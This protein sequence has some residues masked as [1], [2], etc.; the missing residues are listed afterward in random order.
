MR[1][2]RIKLKE[3]E[4]IKNIMHT[5]KKKKNRDIP[6]Q[7]NNLIL[8][9]IVQQ[10]KNEKKSMLLSFYV[11]IQD[12][13]DKF[14]SN[15]CN[16]TGKI[17]VCFITFRASLQVDQRLARRPERHRRIQTHSTEPGTQIFIYKFFQTKIG[18]N[19]LKDSYF[20]CIFQ[21]ILEFV[22]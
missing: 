6:L 12:H 22:G 13:D 5:E 3:K 10:K 7:K 19:F 2:Y 11:K 15:I 1:R 8:L 20:F 16:K 14:V 21:I 17:F 9:L 18:N 4:I